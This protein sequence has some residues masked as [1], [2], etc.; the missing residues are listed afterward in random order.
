MERNHSSSDSIFNTKQ[1]LFRQVAFHEAGHAVAIYLRNKQQQLPPVYLQIVL[2]PHASAAFQHNYQAKVEGGR[3][4]ENLPLSLAELSA[5]DEPAY[6]AAFEADIVN[7]LAGPLAEAKYVARRD[8]EA[9]SRHLV[10][11]DALRFYGG[12]SDLDVVNEY[13]ESVIECRQQGNRIIEQLFIEAFKFIDL[14]QHW[15]VISAL[16]T[17]IIHSPKIVIPCE[18]I[19]AIIEHA[20]QST[21]RMAN[22]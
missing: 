16:A 1:E 10:N 12:A 11:L 4:I 3:L 21:K 8:D 2:D 20:L 18:E 15:Y 14:P 7:L 6:L 19:T 17:H 13:I 9:I 22:R 5:M